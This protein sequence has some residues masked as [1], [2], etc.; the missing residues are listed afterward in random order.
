MSNANKSFPTSMQTYS[1]HNLC[2]GTK[3]PLLS[4]L[5]GEAI[6]V[7]FYEELITPLQQTCGILI[8]FCHKL[9]G[10]TYLNYKFPLHTAAVT[11]C[12]RSH[13]C[14]LTHIIARMPLSKGMSQTFS[15]IL[16][17]FKL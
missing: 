16:S 10:F 4:L 7:T 8:T 2:T 13:N 14:H 9:D 3:D 12:I 5:I 15:V 6:P 1:E 11:V 17:I